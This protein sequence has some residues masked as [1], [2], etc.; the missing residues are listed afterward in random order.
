MGRHKESPF[1]RAECQIKFLK[2]SLRAEA[3]S[4]DLRQAISEVRND[5]ERQV[6][7]YKEKSLGI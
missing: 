1:F 3:V 2:K 7:K 5:L 4:E 6:K